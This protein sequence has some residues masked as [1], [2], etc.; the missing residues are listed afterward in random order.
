MLKEIAQDLKI[1][2]KEVPTTPRVYSKMPDD[3]KKKRNHHNRYCWTH[4]A[5]AHDSKY[6]RFC[7]PGHKVEATKENRMGGSNAHCS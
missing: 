7:A 6:C 3:C 1:V 4:G 5:G 2:K